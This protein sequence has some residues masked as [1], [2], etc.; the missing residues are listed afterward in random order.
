MHGLINYNTLVQTCSNLFSLKGVLSAWL[1][2][3]QTGLNLFKLVCFHGCA[4]FMIQ[5]MRYQF[6]LVQT[7]F[8]SWVCWVHGSIDYK[9][10]Q[11]CWNLFSFMGVLSSWSS[12]WQSGSNL[13]K[14]VFI[15]G[16]ADYMVLWTPRLIQT[17]SNLFLLVEV[18]ECNGWWWLNYLELFNLVYIRSDNW[19][20]EVGNKLTLVAALDYF[21]GH[22]LFDCLGLHWSQLFVHLHWY[23]A[24]SCGLLA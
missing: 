15:H 6:K 7:C 4:E 10:V 12:W 22:G 9:L 13:L 24:S 5:L 21:I 18:L 20:T 8:F 23:A 19:H 2:W 17:G 14:L 11:T 3:L 16:C 1:N